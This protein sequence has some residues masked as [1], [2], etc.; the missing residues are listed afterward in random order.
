MLYRSAVLQQITGREISLK[1]DGLDESGGGRLPAYWQLE[2]IDVDTFVIK[3]TSICVFN[4]VYTLAAC[5]QR[6][7]VLATTGCLYST[8]YGSATHID[9]TSS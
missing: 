1:L 8:N 3:G 5:K 9:N 4:R 6:S 7:L 2:Y